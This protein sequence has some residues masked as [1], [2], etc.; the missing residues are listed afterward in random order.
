M[1]GHS[2]ESYYLTADLLVTGIIVA[3]FFGSI[4]TVWA[5]SQSGVVWPWSKQRPRMS[6]DDLARLTQAVEQLHDRLEDMQDELGSMHDR[7]EFTERLLE[8][9]QDDA[10]SGGSGHLPPGP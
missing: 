7:L 3:A 4:A 8:R 6:S 5:W 2:V 1:R 9:P 10:G